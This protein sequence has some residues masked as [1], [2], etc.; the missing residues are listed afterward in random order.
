MK[1]RLLTILS[2]V[3]LILTLSVFNSCEKPE[4]LVTDNV[5]TGGLIKPTGSVPYKLGSTP[6]VDLN[7]SIPQGAAIKSILVY[8]QFTHNADATVSGKVLLTTIDIAGANATAA[9]EQ[10]FS[11]TWADLS[12][13]LTLPAYTVPADEMLADIG[14]SFELSYVSVMSSDNAEIINA[15]TTLIGVANFF[16]G[17]YV[18]T[19]TFNHP[20]AGVRPLNAEKDLVAVSSSQC[21]TSLGDLGGAGYNVIINIDPVTYEVTCLTPDGNPAE[22]INGDPTDASH[23]SK[24]DPATGVIDTWYYY[25]GGGGPRI[26]H[27]IFTPK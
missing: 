3:L 16:A 10:A 11:V 9:K 1:N 7:V 27:E 24:Y 22:V 25:V 4:D 21:K 18:A 14:D 8:K 5:R 13:G 17:K 15:S 20:T 23:V 2:F 6:T 12:S 26:I 19:G